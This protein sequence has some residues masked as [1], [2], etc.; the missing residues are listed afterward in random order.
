MPRRRRRVSRLEM[1][2]FF[3]LLGLLVGGSVYLDSRGAATTATV[4]GKQEEVS[5][6]STPQPTWFRWYRVGVEFETPDGAPGMA[7]VTVPRER[8]DSLRQGD[9]IAIRYLPAFPLLA[10][11][12]DRSTAVVAWESAA[13]LVS[14]PALTALVIWLVGGGAAL[15][16]LARISTVVA[17]VAGLV[18]IAAAF[19]LLFPPPTPVRLGPSET[20]ARVE[21]VRLITK[22]P[23]RRTASRRYGG[24][25]SSDD[26]RR[27]AQPYHVVQLRLAVPGRAD[28]V[29][30][31]DA[32]DS[33]SVPGLQFGAVLPVRYD[34]GAARE[35]RLKAGTRTF[36]E[37][38][39]YHFRVP[40][41]GVGVL[42]LLAVLT[43][44][45]RREARPSPAA[46]RARVLPV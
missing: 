14:D 43:W 40:V 17:A 46:D 3:A 21:S 41:I 9:S 22:A 6:S 1:I 8:F 2:Y 36:S 10:R 24:R 45:S 4:S 32:V 35:A 39:R 11:T 15:W 12:V 30:A 20:M 25:R 27:L 23:E 31:V 18:W 5:V 37:R 33:A 34:P 44:R 19:P 42:V 29:L 7:T 26:I 16:V 13:M 38:N 28:S